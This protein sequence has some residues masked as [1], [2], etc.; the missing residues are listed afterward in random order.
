MKLSLLKMQTVKEKQLF[1]TSTHDNKK[2]ECSRIAHVGQPFPSTQNQKVCTIKWF[3]L[4]CS[5]KLT[6]YE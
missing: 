6:V 3:T 1:T 4:L 2:H 5:L